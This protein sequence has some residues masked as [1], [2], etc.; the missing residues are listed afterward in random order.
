MKQFRLKKEAVPFFRK[1]CATQILDLETWKEYQVDIQALEVVEDA[2]VYYGGTNGKFKSLCGW[3]DPE[4]NEDGGAHF[5]FTIRFPSVKIQEY[6]EFSNGKIIRELM[7]K[8]QQE[9]SW[10]F[11]D[12]KNQ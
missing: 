9:V 3:S 7:D 11:N 10:F 2:C 1:E 12:Y 8:I 6:D 4:T 5:I